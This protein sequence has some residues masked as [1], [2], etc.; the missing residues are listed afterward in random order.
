LP[1]IGA[2]RLP[3]LGVSTS[4]SPSALGFNGA[5]LQSQAVSYMSKPKKKPERRATRGMLERLHYIDA[6]LRRGEKLNCSSLYDAFGVGRVTVWKDVEQL[7]ERGRPI[8]FDPQRNTYYYT[9]AVEPMPDEVITEGELFTLMVARSALEQYRGT[10]YFRQLTKSYEKLARELKTKVPFSADDYAAR[11]SFKGMGTP[12]IDPAVFNLVSRGVARRVMVTFDY[13][14]P[15]ACAARRRTAELWHVTHRGG[16]WYVVG[17]DPAANGRRTFALTR[18]TNPVL[19]LTKFVIPKDFSSEKHFANAFSVL[20]GEGDYRIVIRFHGATAVRVQE[21]EWH[22]SERWRDLGGGT[23]E[24]ELRLGALE[25]IERWVL[26]WG[27]EAEV[28]EPKALRD[29]IALTA[30]SLASSYRTNGLLVS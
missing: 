17:F 11:V 9:E 26:S 27:V 12:K 24:L 25:E 1:C 19:T 18:I 2:P 4:T 29:R 30:E 28:I 22:E 7:R 23:V 10:P 6:A 13:C 3:R 14:K 15:A 20:G 5:F 16:L 8:E 21:C